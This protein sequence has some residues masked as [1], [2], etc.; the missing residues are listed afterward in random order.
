LSDPMRDRQ[1]GLVSR[2]A[3]NLL[4]SRPVGAADEDVEVLRMPL[5][6]CVTREGVSAA[7]EVRHLVL[8]ELSEGGPVKVTALL[9]ESC[10]GHARKGWHQHTEIAQPV[11]FTVELP[12]PTRQRTRAPHRASAPTSRT[13]A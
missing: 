9:V 5:D 7:D 13:R 1:I 11:P 10:C 3:K 8:V 12:R 2:F 6:S 4:R